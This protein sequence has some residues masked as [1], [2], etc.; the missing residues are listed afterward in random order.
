[1][2]KT[3]KDCAASHIT[4]G[5]SFYHREAKPPIGFF[6]DPR[7]RTKRLDQNA[8]NYSRKQTTVA[9]PS[10]SPFFSGF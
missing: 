9:S 3:Q 2:R 4:G 10:P 1:L 7:D 8:Q 6:A 5:V